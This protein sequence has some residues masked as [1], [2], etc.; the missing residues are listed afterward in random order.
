MWP[1]VPAI[2]S[3]SASVVEKNAGDIFRLRMTSV[4]LFLSDPSVYFCLDNSINCAK[5]FTMEVAG[6]VK[7]TYKHDMPMPPCQRMWWQGNQTP[8]LTLPSV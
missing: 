4:F 1:N 5:K 8:C 7:G 2:L 3:F 6:I